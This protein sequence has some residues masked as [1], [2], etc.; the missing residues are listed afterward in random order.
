MLPVALL[1]LPLILRHV[2]HI[3][4]TRHAPRQLQREGWLSVAIW[5]VS[6]VIL[7][8][9]MLTHTYRTSLDAH[10]WIGY[11]ALWLGALGRMVSIRELGAAF[12]EFIRV[13]EEQ[14]LIDTGIYAYVRHPLHYFLMFEMLA[15]AWLNRNL[16]SWGIILVAGITLVFRELHEEQA[17]IRAYG[18]RYLEYRQR[19]VALVDLIR[20]KGNSDVQESA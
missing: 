7:G 15:M 17:L 10:Y 6:Y 13:E 2:H 16:W 20:W 5:F 8:L 1:A 11:V 18:N 12:S 14:P 3:W 19:T 9:G 4:C